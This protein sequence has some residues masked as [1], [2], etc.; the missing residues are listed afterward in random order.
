MSSPYPSLNTK[1]YLVVEGKV[2]TWHARQGKCP[3][4]ST[5]AQATQRLRGIRAAEGEITVIGVEVGLAQLNY[6]PITNAH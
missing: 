3:I 1:K 5:S 6:L 2:R 4:V